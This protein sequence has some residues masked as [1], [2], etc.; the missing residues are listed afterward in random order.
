[1]LKQIGLHEE[2]FNKYAGPL[3][4]EFCTFHG[5]FRVS[6]FRAELSF[7]CIFLEQHHVFEGR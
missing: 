4:Q 5:I 6:H 7:F 2:V 1:M 3:I